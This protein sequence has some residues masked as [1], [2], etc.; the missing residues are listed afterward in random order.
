MLFCL[1][2]FNIV[3]KAWN[4]GL[5][6]S[7]WHKDVITRGKNQVGIYKDDVLDFTEQQ[8]NFLWTGLQINNEK[9]FPCKCSDSC[10]SRKS[11][12]SKYH[13]KRY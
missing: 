6:E 4:Y 7:V 11:L 5:D 9:K 10:S 13:D 1:L 8:K 3:V 12:F 2:D